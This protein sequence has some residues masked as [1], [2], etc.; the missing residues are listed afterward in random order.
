MGL[1][2][3]WN[4]QQVT[5][6]HQIVAVNEIARVK[7]SALNNFI[8]ERKDGEPAQCTMFLSVHQPRPRRTRAEYPTLFTPG[9][10]EPS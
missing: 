8:P 5:N 1:H 6:P 3:L 9:T 7:Q 4:Y 10:Q 2:L